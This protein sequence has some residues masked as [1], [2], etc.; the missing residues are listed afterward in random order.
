MYVVVVDFTVLPAHVAAFRAAMVDNARA[1]REREPGCRQFDVCADSADPA[2]V[3]LYEVYD[4][5]AAFDAHLASPHF[6]AFDAMV[7]SWIGAKA[8][9]ALERV[10]P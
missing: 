6:R 4:D 9:R 10:D 3:F 5:R 8:V 2:R 1:S 7:A